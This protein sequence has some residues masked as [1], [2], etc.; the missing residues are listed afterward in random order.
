MEQLKTCQFHTKIAKHLLFTNPSPLVTALLA[1]WFRVC[2]GVSL[3]PGCVLGCAELGWRGQ[4]SRSAGGTWEHLSHP[5]PDDTREP[6]AGPYQLHVGSTH[7]LPQSEQPLPQP[8]TSSQP[9]GL[10]QSWHY[11]S[12]VGRPCPYSCCDR[13]TKEAKKERYYNN[14]L[15]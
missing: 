7:P 12:T 4:P 9:P 2:E 11:R 3:I 14:I 1:H 10:W 5:G 15:V 6:T 8:D 13:S